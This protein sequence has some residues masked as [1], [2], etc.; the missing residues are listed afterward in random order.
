MLI[1]EGRH[2]D[3]VD[4]LFIHNRHEQSGTTIGVRLDPEWHFVSAALGIQDIL[5]RR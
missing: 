3:P 4:R 2:L 1:R 5:R